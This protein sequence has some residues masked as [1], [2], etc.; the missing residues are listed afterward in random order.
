MRICVYTGTA[1]PLLGGQEI[2]VDTLAREFQDQGHEVVVL[3][4]RSAG[5]DKRHDREQPYVVARHPRFVS[6]RRLVSLYRHYL[7]R[8]HR[9]HRFD[10]LH[11]HGVY[12]TGWIGSLCRQDWGLPLVVTSHGE[13]GPSSSHRLHQPMFRRR[14]ASALNSADALVAI[15]RFTR[16]AYTELAPECESRIVDIPNGVHLKEIGQPVPRPDD[17]DAAV[18]PGAYV[19]FLGRLVERKGVDVLLKALALMPPAGGVQLVIAG[20]GAERGDLQTLAS[21]LKLEERV[22]FVGVAR[23]E[24]KSYL[25]QNALCTVV[26]TRTWEGLPLVVLEAFAAGKAVI[27]SRVPGVVDVV[28][29]G[30]TGMLVPPDTPDALSAVLLHAFRNPTDMSRLGRQARQVA[31]EYSWSNVAGAHLQLYEQILHAGPARVAA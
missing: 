6:K 28:H 27:A 2:V 8:L 11:C 25:L 19:L 17:L 14:Y 20:D 24:R 9:R 23:D 1:L 30:Q 7:L 21:Q 5:L 3:A 12:P 22:R 26:P 16:S 13:D 10:V 18:R 15:S 29:P 4:P 31:N